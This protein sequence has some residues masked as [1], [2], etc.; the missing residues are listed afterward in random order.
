METPEHS[1]VPEK[2]CPQ[3]STNQVADIA[4]HY[5]RVLCEMVDL[6]ADLLRMVHKEAQQ[7]DEARLA[8]A[9]PSYD[10]STFP[11]A[12]SASDLAAAYDLIFRA[13]RR[14]MLLDAKLA[15]QP[16]APSAAQQRVAA[17][18]RIIRAVEDAI[19]RNAQPDQVETL[20]AELIE[21]LDTPDLDDEIAN[22][23]IAEIVTDM[24]RDFGIA[25]LPGT[26]PWQR[27]TPHDI[28]ILTARA[29]KLAAW[30]S[31][32]RAALLAAPPKPPP[33]PIP[34]N[35]PPTDPAAPRNRWKSDG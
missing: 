6:G 24:C 9:K 7:A 4:N 15:E 1:S 30:P 27:R 2:D 33:R 16:K 28:A 22:R 12:K 10:P 26:H 17:R 35:H 32:E 34:G 29:E 23:T 13:I 19:V 21:R 25:A 3:H 31:A 20:R 5:R 8:A 11:A 14:A 18:K